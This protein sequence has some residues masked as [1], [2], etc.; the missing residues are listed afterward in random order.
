MLTTN[1]ADV[2]G[3]AR[4]M[5]LHGMSRDAW[6]R[7]ERGGS[8]YY[9]VVAPGY[10]YNMGDIQ[11][12]LGLAQLRRLD[13]MNA[14]RAELAARLSARLAECDAIETPA[15]R[16]EVHHVWHLYVIRLRS[17]A[18]SIDRAAFI[19]E[20]ARRGIG[21][22]V[23]FIPI[24]YHPFYREGFGFRPGD[25]PAAEDAYERLISLPLYPGMTDEDADRVA[26]AVL[27]TAKQFRR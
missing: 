25:Y 11:A 10:K 15:A 8:W 24:H 22:S 26:E 4:L 12:A 13:A 2:E 21:T 5:T 16:P 17:E 20:L 3:R 1:R 7:Y 14:R 19:E 27:D 6:K 23:H 18:L 9:E